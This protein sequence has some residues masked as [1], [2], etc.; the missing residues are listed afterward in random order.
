MNPKGL[1]R[2]SKTKPGRVRRKGRRS[3][4]K[5]VVGKTGRAPVRTRV[6]GS[7]GTDGA[8]LARSESARM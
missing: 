4:I 6:A 8:I 1:E 5:W 3:Q 7:L 2:T